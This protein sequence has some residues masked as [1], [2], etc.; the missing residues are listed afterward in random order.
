MSKKRK[1]LYLVYI[2]YFVAV[3][4][5]AV[6][7]PIVD[8]WNKINPHILGLPFAQFTVICISVL[9]IIG[10]TTWYYFEGK[11]NVVERG[12]REEGGRL[13]H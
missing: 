2:I 11:L 7:P 10:L 4:L 1:Q 12:I 3:L 9:L 6:F 5:L 8:L 13:D